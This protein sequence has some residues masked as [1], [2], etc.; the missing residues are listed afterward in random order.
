MNNW[1]KK[2]S[3]MRRYDLTASMY[4]ER[5]FEE[6]EAKYKA[7]IASL[8]LNSSSFGAI[9]DVGCGSGQFLKHITKKAELIVG[10]DVS[11]GL[12]LMAKQR[13]KP[14]ANVS[15]VLADADNLPLRQGVFGHIF[16]FT[17]LQNMPKPVK[18]IRQLKEA[19]KRDASFVITGLKA[20]ISLETLDSYL[21]SAEMKL[22]TLVNNESLK[23]YIAV[24]VKQ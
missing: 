20:A 18:T 10:L 23:C 13:S 22:V 11:R 9:L 24:S 6:Q 14:F 17:V 15:I 19:G 8:N 2:R 12:L 4:D 7:A 3:V 5:Y 1:S 16:A 21:K